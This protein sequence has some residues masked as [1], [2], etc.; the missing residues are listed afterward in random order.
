MVASAHVFNT[1][2]LYPNM[3]PVNSRRRYRSAR[4]VEQASQTRERVVEAAHAAFVEDGWQK[5]T[6]AGIARAAGVSAETIYATFGTKRALLEELVRK[7][8]RGDRPD[9]PLLE[10][11]GPAAIA[12]AGDQH[13]QIALFAADITG[14]LSRVAPLM[15]VVRA[16]AE[17]DSELAGLYAGLHRGR[18]RNLEFIVDALLARRPLKHGLHREAAIDSIWRLA[19]PEL[20]LLMTGVEGVS[21]D[22]YGAWL[23]ATLEAA[24][25]AA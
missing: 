9:Q 21:A 1:V 25:L 7:A 10:Q 13:R 6:I 17:A 14:V 20:F 8:V 15:G 11:T 24:L 4:R 22:A 3:G 19:S 5:A 2:R 18:R 12:A 23:A 16:A